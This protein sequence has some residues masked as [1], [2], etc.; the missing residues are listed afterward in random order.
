MLLI[1]RQFPRFCPGFLVHDGS[2][3]AC[4]HR[5]PEPNMTISVSAGIIPRF[6]CQ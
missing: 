6:R 3:G 4:E 1:Q 2:N 5:L